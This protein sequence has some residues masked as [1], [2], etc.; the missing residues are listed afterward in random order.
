MRIRSFIDRGMKITIIWPISRMEYFRIAMQGHPI[1]ASRRR[2]LADLH[3]AKA[4]EGEIFF[5]ERRVGD[6]IEI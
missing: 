6:E 4:K 1:M 3:R 5:S 2:G